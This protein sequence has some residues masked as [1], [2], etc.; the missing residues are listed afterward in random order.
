[1]LISFTVKNF[2][3]FA[4]EATVSFER[5]R[6]AEAHEHY[7]Q[8][9]EQ[10]ISKALA[11]IGP[12]ASGKSNLLKALTF[13]IWFMSDSFGELKPGEELRLRPH[14]FCEGKPTEFT[15]EFFID[16][17]V[18]KYEL[19]LDTFKVLHE[20]LY[21]R[22]IDQGKFSYL[23]KR[24]WVG[25]SYRYSQKLFEFP[26]DQLSAIRSNA[27]FVSTALQYNVQ[28]AVEIYKQFLQKFISSFDERGLVETD[29]QDEASEF[30]YKN[31]NAADLM[32]DVMKNIDLGLSDIEISPP[33]SRK[34]MSSHVEFSP[35]KEYYWHGVHHD[36]PNNREFSVLYLDESGG[37]QKMY[38][39][40]ARIIPVLLNGG[41]AVI[42][43]LESELHPDM[44]VYV[45]NL[46]F[47][48]QS[49]PHGAQILFTTHSAELLNF[50]EKYQV[51]LVEKNN[52]F[53][54]AWKLDQVKGIRPEDNLYKK[55]RAGVYGA[56]PDLY[57][58]RTK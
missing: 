13:L 30:F 31:K 42:D 33:L 36:K 39:F 35:I 29:A 41:V 48:K 10:S 3:S 15:L 46:F 19:A 37:T 11:V 17:K 50:L 55:Y 34:K 2:L 9:G 27:S 21:C 14:A 24:E 4:E 23:F 8:H 51:I 32:K 53:S 44:L 1:M 56:T 57:L 22:S 6:R 38:C 52:T 28:R 47:S 40:L 26:K 25:T 18:Y 12:N 45:L 43:E 54:E 20:A 16:K 7:V 58:P 5:S 49:N